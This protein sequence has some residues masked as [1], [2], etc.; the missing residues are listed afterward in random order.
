MYLKVSII[1]VCFNSEKTIR[2]TIESVIN[3]NYSEI[4]YIIVDGK[5][6]DKTLS[7]IKSYHKSIKKVISEKDH[8]MYDA[9]NKGIRAASGDLIGILNSDD[10]YSD[11][12]VISSI[13]R[14][15]TNN[16]I[17]IAWGDVAFIDKKNK[18]KRLY[19]G[20]DI[21][22]SSFNNGI[23]P[24]HPSVFIK[25]NCYEKFGYFNTK[26]RIAA[27]YDLLL[28]FLKLNNLRYFY[29][30]KVLVKMK[31]GGVSNRSFSNVALLN[32]EIYEIHKSNGVPI[33][34]FNLMKKIPRRIMEL[35]LKP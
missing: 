16:Q 5:S 26:Y 7:T 19:S 12:N 9:L 22:P 8:G 18:V 29:M 23:M 1:T 27:D 2:D 17:N 15:F 13:V 32:K 30:P 21:S 33:S 28:R 31:L 6:K 20:G 10:R 24:P 3:Q 4:E 14:V 35:V 34:I 25:K 11:E